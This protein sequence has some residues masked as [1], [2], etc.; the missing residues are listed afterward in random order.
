MR[1]GVDHKFIPISNLD[2][3]KQLY[4]IPET[5]NIWK[6]YFLCKAIDH[7]GKGHFH[8][9]HKFMMGFSQNKVSCLGS[10]HYLW[11]GPGGKEGVIKSNCKQ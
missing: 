5:N 8:V 11:Q 4:C 9:N 7:S 2:S 1:K 3:T 6:T 10:S